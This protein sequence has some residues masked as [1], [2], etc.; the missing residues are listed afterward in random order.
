MPVYR[1]GIELT[2]P[3]RL[4]G[5]VTI[6]R[7][8]WAGAPANYALGRAEQLSPQLTPWTTD[9]V[10]LRTFV[11]SATHFAPDYT[12]TFS[13]SHADENGVVTT[14][15][16]DWY[17]YS[18]RSSI[19]FN[20]NAGA[21][22]VGRARGHRRYYAALLTQ[23]A[24]MIVRQRDGMNTIL[25]QRVFEHEPEQRH[26]LEFRLHGANLEFIVDD[27]LCLVATDSA[28]GS[29]GAGFVVHRGAIL[30]E[31]FRVRGL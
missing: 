22:L 4:D 30:A 10:W 11:S 16:R 7:L 25:A 19:V 12:T 27:V 15:T 20:H 3:R 26:E 28:Y 8:D 31:G 21:G 24:A 6:E 29:G 2:S 13:I 18:V 1:L 9:A 5:C 17:D 14:G 23:Q